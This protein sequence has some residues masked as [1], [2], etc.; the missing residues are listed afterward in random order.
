[1][2]DYEVCRHETCPSGMRLLSRDES[3]GNRVDRW[4]CAYGHRW[5]VAVLRGVTYGW[6]PVSPSVRGSGHRGVDDG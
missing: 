6:T 4:E 3:A 1:M 5:R 2:T